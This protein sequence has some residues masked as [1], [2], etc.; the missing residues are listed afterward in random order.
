M[1]LFGINLVGVNPETGQKLLFTVSLIVVLYVIAK[2]ITAV[3]VFFDA[4]G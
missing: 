3:D 4:A 1:E 2:V